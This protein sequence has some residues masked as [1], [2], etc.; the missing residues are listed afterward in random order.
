MQNETIVDNY[1]SGKLLKAIRQGVTALGKTTDTITLNDLA[2]V[3]EFHIGGRQATGDLLDQIDLGPQDRLLD[4]G[5]GIG[6]TSRFAAATYG[7]RVDGIDLTPEFI[8]AGREICKWLGLQDL[9]TLRVANALHNGFDDNSFDAA[10]MLHVGMN[11]PDK[12]ALFAETARVLRPGGRFALYD[13]MKNDDA[14]REY[15]VPWATGPDMCAIA[16]LPTYKDGLIAAGFEIMAI[17]DRTEFAGAFFER[18]KKGMQSSAG[19]PPIGL[20]QIMGAETPAKIAN[21]VAN[22]AS[23]RIS[24]VEIIAHKV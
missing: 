19:Q 18:M 5:C 8:E 10:C 20:H 11:I 16:S 24:P 14:A 23:G 1:S 22:I 6:G 12:S 13:V 2:P 3:E 7:A 21:M 4:I 9:V 15:P 17:R